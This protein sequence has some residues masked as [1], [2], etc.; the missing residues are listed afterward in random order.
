MAINYRK[1]FGK[2][3]LAQQANHIRAHF[4]DGDYGFAGG[5]FL[6]WEGT[7][8]PSPYSRQYTLCLNYRQG[9]IPYVW[10]VDPPHYLENVRYEHTYL[11]NRLC[12]YDPDEWTW[13]SSEWLADTVI[14]WACLWLFYYEDWLVT[15]KWNGGGKHPGDKEN[16]PVQTERKFDKFRRK[17]K[18]KQTAAIECI[19]LSKIKGSIKQR[20]MK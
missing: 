20:A 5:N 1:K 9:G 6:V 17:K 3:S 13:H 4:P 19:R 8:R 7:V 10:V 14:P 15:G 11:G 18:K 12:L 2:K 16:D